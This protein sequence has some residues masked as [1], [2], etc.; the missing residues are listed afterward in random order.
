MSYGKVSAY[1]IFPSQQTPTAGLLFEHWGEGNREEFVDEATVLTRLGF[2]S[3][4]LDAPYRRPTEYEPKLEEP[5][6]A[7]LQWIV[8]VRRGVDLLLELLSLTPNELG[9]VGRGNANYPYTFVGYRKIDGVALDDPCIAH[10]QLLALAPAL[11]TFLNELHNFPIVEAI[12]LDVQEHTPTLWKELY[13]KRY[14]DLQKRVFQQLDTRLRAKTKQ[15]WESFLNDTA[16][17]A[18]QSKLIHRDLSGEHIFC[19]PE[20][21]V[22]M[23][24]IDWGDVTIG[25]P[26]ID[27]V[28][29]HHVG[30]KE[31]VE[32]VLL[33]CQNTIDTAFWQ[34]IDFYLHYRPFSQLLYGSYS[35]N[36]T[37]MR[38]GVEGLRTMFGE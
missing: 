11:A 14:I 21:D 25:D 8:D 24:V 32:H 4:C 37:C 10:E 29:L 20:R 33:R 9:Y 34:R 15:L 19:E 12:Q 3:L 31:F 13:Q 26:A 23:G 38:Q 16:L 7:E 6:Q 35:K 27:F 2:V 17:F 5:P 28:G 36:E 30:G 18:F 1:L 22:L